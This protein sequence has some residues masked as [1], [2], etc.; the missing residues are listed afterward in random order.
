MMVGANS[1]AVACISDDPASAVIMA[2]D[3]KA[4]NA[5]AKSHLGK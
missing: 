5:K 4:E 2:L 1:A 3:P